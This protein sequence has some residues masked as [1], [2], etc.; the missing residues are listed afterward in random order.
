MATVLTE[1][2]HCSCNKYHS[3]NNNP[4]CWCGHLEECHIPV[5]VSADG[6]S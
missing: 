5:E 1:C 6:T 4:D 3:K 2:D